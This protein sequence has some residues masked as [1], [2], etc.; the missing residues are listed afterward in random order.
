MAVVGDALGGAPVVLEDNGAQAGVVGGLLGDDV[1]GRLPR[2]L[3]DGEVFVPQRRTLEQ[4]IYP[5]KKLH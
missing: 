1:N 4:K 5:P 2:P 3:G